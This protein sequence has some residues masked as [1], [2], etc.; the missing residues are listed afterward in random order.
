MNSLLEIYKLI[1]FSELIH[2]EDI[3]PNAAIFD[4]AA[5]IK[6]CEHLRN[7]I[8]MLLFSFVCARAHF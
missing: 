2:V 1:L 8:I 4:I 7:F 3:V 5:V 6:N